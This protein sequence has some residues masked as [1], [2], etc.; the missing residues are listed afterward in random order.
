MKSANG[1]A[2][3]NSGGGVAAPL[4]PLG[5][6]AVSAFC[7]GLLAREHIAIVGQ[8][9]LAEMVLPLLA[10]L[11]LMFGRA[12]AVLTDRLF[13]GFALAGL[14]SLLGYLLSDLVAGTDA[15]RAL[16]G[17]GR[18]FILVVSGL[19]LIVLAAHDRRLPWWFLLGLAVGSMARLVLTGAA[20]VAD[21]KL[22]WGHPLQILALA[23]GGAGPLLAATA[24]AGLGAVHILL[25]SR[26]QG[27]L[28]VVVA[29]ILL[30]RARR[31]RPG[32]AAVRQ[33]VLVGTLV[34]AFLGGA[35]LLLGATAD[36]YG[37]RRTLSN[38]ARFAGLEVGIEAIVASPFIGYGSWTENPE[39]A[40]Q[41]RRT[42]RERTDFQSRRRSMYSSHDL[43]RQHSQILQAWVEGGLL[44]AGFF[45]F[46]GYWLVRTLA[47][48]VT[49]IRFD[50]YYAVYLYTTM[51][52]LWHLLMSPFGGQARLDIAVAVAVIYLVTRE[53]PTAEKEPVGAGTAAATLPLRLR[54]RPADDR[55]ARH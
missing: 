46:Y 4:P 29:A 31:G 23:F 35:W 14:V 16:K 25:D 51:A 26:I 43:F 32:P 17:S 47:Q 39:F 24:S 22:G 13:I 33:L 12:R 38:T 2:A 21:W 8:F 7:T 18:V 34:L 42:I 11:L 40:E 36:D 48:Q 37:E 52:G 5:L 50:R 28:A 54:F 10:I 9:Y 15:T 45:F 3:V 49:R 55:P 41:L 44:G 6:A 30:G 53:A 20:L 1:T 27:V 19:S